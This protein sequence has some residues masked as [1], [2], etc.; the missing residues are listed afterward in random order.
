M[1]ERDKKKKKENRNLANSLTFANFN[2][3]IK[4]LHIY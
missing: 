1:R 4:L 3:F 2:Q